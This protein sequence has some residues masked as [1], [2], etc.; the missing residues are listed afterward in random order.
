MTN[1]APAEILGRHV[2]SE[3]MTSDTKAAERFYT[4]VLAWTAE[5]FG[6][7]PM[8][9]TL[10]KRTG[11]D[12][13]VAGLLKTPDGMH[14]PPFWSIYIA[15]PNFDEAVAKAKQL[16]GSTLSDVIDVPTVGR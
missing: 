9:Y 7:S 10:F 5:P 6:D 2:W 13:G 3:L 1:T 4:A 11:S 8:P 14:M 15:V 12:R 16:G